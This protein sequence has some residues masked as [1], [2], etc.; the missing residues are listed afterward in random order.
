MVN[1]IIKAL[2]KINP[3]HCKLST[4]NYK[5]L[6]SGG[7]PKAIHESKYLER[8]VAY[9]FYHQFRKLIEADEIKLEEHVLIQAEVDKR[10]QDIKG[11]NKIPDFLVH[12][13]SSSCSKAVIEFKLANR[14]WGDIKDDFDKL[15][16]FKEILK[17][18]ELVEVLIGKPEDIEIKR[19][20]LEPLKSDEDFNM[21]VIFYDITKAK[22]EELRINYKKEITG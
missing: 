12:A 18:K 17:Y 8:P 15:L 4:L 10:Y 21:I 22:A 20:W 2:E 1:D 19:K 7:V 3:G 6:E 16:D 5:E 9:E 14:D 13:P 11:L